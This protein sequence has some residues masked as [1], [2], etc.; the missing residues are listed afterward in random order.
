MKYS[1]FFI[2][3][4]I[5]FLYAQY[6]NVQIS[7]Q[8]SPSEPAI[9][10][11][12]NN[13]NILFAGANLDNYYVST[14]AGLTWLSNNL[15]S[16]YGVW[17]DPCLLIGNSGEFYYF[18]LSNATSWLDRIIC[19]KSTN[20]GQTF[21]NG[22]YFGLNGNKDQDKEW[23][24]IDRDNGNIYALWTQFDDYGSSSPTCKT[25]IMF[26]KSTDNASTWSLPIKINQVDGNCEDGD[27]TVEGATPAIGLN[28]E[29]YTSW[30]SPDGI[31][32]DRSTDY[33]ATWLDNDILVDAMPDGWTFSIPGLDRANGMPITKC[34]RSGGNYN[35]TIYINWSDQ[36]NG[37]ND[38]DI[39][40]K[41]S[42]D[43]GNTWSNIIRVNDDAPGNQQFLSWMDIDQTDGTIY[44]VFYDRRNYNDLRT[45]VYLAYS[46]D[47]GDNFTNVKISE[48]PFIPN[49]NA[50]F[51]DYT[52]IAAHN[53]VIRPIWGRLDGTISSIWTAI[54]T[55]NT[56]NT[57]QFITATN[58]DIENY[59]NP[60]TDN[61]VLKFKLRET[62][63]VSLSFYN[64]LGEK[65][66]QIIDNKPFG[67]GKHLIKKPF[68][69]LNLTNG[70][71]FYHLKI[72]NKTFIKKIIIEK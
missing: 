34:D 32:F 30:G 44:I 18:H 54:I 14:D 28:G 42:T 13:T 52:N 41:K 53:G 33:G 3:I 10:I 51:G 63:N 60:I 2:L 27:S 61:F 5:N 71:Y 29:I 59:P 46:T 69:K 31:Y 57:E 8:N 7:N 72:G 67:Y 26:T 17:G 47:G 55:K 66:I 58:F 21:N 11:N 12:P 1:L 56:L 64:I 15:V 6:T 49:S 9:A 40:L 22:S 19:Q 39:W 70:I 50:F 65:V 4:N 48:S 68:E 24:T 37:T 43:G 36:R 38:T 62:K 16:T 25:Q 45:D 35:G 23:A 20:N